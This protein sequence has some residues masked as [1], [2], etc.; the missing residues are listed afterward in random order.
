MPRPIRDDERE[1]LWNLL[2]EGQGM[3][4]GK[5]KYIKFRYKNKNYKRSRIIYQLYHGVILYNDEIIHHKDRNRINDKITNLELKTGYEHRSEHNKDLRKKH[6]ERIK[7][8]KLSKEI[9]DRIFQLRQEQI[10][11][12]IKVN[13]SK[14]AKE[15]GISNQIIIRCYLLGIRK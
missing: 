9:L 3:S 7:S 1:F 13:Y 6:K 11:K 4:S 2:L 5:S 14:M 8:N 15:L 12:G 10:D